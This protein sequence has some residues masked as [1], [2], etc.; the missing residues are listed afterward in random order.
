MEQ[1]KRKIS[2]RKVLQLVVTIILT[3]GCVMA[4]SSATK[5]QNDR[6]VDGLSINIKNPQY[7]FVDKQDIKQ[8][9]INGNSVNGQNADLNNIDIN[10]LE[11]V[12]N[13]NPWVEDAQVYIDNQKVLHANVTQRIPVARLFDQSGNS[14]YLDRSLQAMPLSGQYIHYTTVVTN[15]PVLKDDSAAMALKGQIVALVRHIE[16]DSF[17]NAQVSQLVVTDDRTFEVV[18][19]LGNQRIILGDTSNMKAK[20][21]NLFAFYKKVLNRVGWDKYEVLD[22]RYKGQVVASPAL[23]WKMP[24]NKG[25]SNMDWVKA[26]IDGGKK[27]SATAAI[28]IMKPIPQPTATKPALQPT[29]AKA[30]PQAKATPVVKKELPKPTV[31]P[32]QEKEKR[33]AITKAD[34]ASKAKPADKKADAKKADAKKEPAKPKYVYPGKNNN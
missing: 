16:R 22:L 9:L 18:P 26:I 25:L 32:K 28:P 29:A 21:D 5:I 19:V 12:I 13:A 27:D 24:S 33:Q 15:V 8:V 2:I 17:W 3:T 7:H 1:K 30:A 10:R 23:P 34:V 4:I 14:Y 31:K 20:F 11:K 6:S